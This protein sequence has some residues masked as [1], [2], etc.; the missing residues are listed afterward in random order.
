MRPKKWG[1]PTKKA[2]WISDTSAKKFTKTSAK[3]QGEK[4]FKLLS[5]WKSGPLVL[6]EASAISL[7]IKFSSLHKCT[8]LSSLTTSLFP[9]SRFLVL[10]ALLPTLVSILFKISQSP[11]FA[12]LPTP[13]YALF[14]TPSIIPSSKFGSLIA[15]ALLLS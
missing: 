1:M 11:K 13:I 5:A 9:K 15:F 4:V 2:I 10:S 6:F 7:S 3:L 14:E 8:L 12:L